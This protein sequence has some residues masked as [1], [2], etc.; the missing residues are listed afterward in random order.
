MRTHATRTTLDRVTTPA[1]PTCD[2]DNPPLLTKTE[3]DAFLGLILAGD[4]LAR[5][6]DRGL[7]QH[8]IGLHQFEVLFVLAYISPNGA[9]PMSEIRRRSPLSQS[10]VSRVVSGLEA[11]GLVRRTTDPT[12]T[13]AVIVSITD[14]GRSMFE[15]TKPSHKRDL[16]RHLFSLL[17]DREL[18]QLAAI[19]T[20]LL[21]AEQNQR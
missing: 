9:M 14:D 2:D 1:S 17:T 13:R 5:A 6:L 12:D 4:T 19:T 16:E 18:N 8:G 11:D 3:A 20:K 21:S 15:T 10:R 7:N